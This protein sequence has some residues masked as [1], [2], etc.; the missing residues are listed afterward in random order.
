MTMLEEIRKRL[1]N[2]KRLTELDK[3]LV[4][5]LYEPAFANGVCPWLSE[6][7]SEQIDDFLSTLLIVSEYYVDRNPVLSASLWGI[8][9]TVQY[10]RHTRSSSSILFESR[11]K[12]EM[13]FIHLRA[14]VATAVI[15]YADRNAQTSITSNALSNMADYESKV[16][17]AKEIL[18]RNT[19]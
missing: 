12:R 4:A 2:G 5:V 6:E 16:K 11:K 8:W 14:L 7:R 13:L 10:L 1:K 3:E 15:H 9:N 19:K 17:E 18:R